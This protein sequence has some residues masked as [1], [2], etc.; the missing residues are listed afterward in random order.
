MKKDVEILKGEIDSWV[1]D[2][3]S[4]LQNFKEIPNLVDEHTQNI[5]H[6]YELIHELKSE[7]YRLKE[8]LSALRLIQ[9]MHLE[10]DIGNVRLKIRK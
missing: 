3:N 1:K 10:A 5:E 9:L 4:E 7:I 8:E 6:N 2:F